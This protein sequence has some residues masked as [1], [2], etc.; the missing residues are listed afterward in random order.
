MSSLTIWNLLAVVIQVKEPEQLLTFF[1]VIILLIPGVLSRG[2]FV[3]QYNSSH[4]SLTMPIKIKRPTNAF[5]SS[6]VVSDHARLLVPTVGTE[7]L[8]IK[9]FDSAVS[10][11]KSCDLIQLGVST[12]ENGTLH[13]TA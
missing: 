2:K 13:M 12:K 3:D 10:H 9:S 5:S 4:G 6:T 1:C 7:S 11:N 8:Q